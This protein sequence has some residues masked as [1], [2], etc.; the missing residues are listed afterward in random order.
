MGVPYLIVVIYLRAFRNNRRL[1][2]CIAD[3]VEVGLNFRAR[4]LLGCWIQ[5]I[6]I[7]VN[8]QLPTDCRC[9]RCNAQFC[10][11][12][13]PVSPTVQGV[14]EMTRMRF[15][16]LRDGSWESYER[17]EQ[18]STREEYAHDPSKKESPN[19]INFDLYW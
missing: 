5:D 8:V 14:W 7:P 9:G 12:R 15:K 13:F 19:I 16:D 17:V 6:C 4:I 11:R 18:V 1:F 2:I 3:G 10:G